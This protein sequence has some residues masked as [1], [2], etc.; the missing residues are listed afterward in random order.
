MPRK[1]AEDQL[2][3]HQETDSKLSVHC[4]HFC[5]IGRLGQ[6]EVD[7]FLAYAMWRVVLIFFGDL[8]LCSSI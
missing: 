3:I 2:N 8:V 5:K 6:A 7:L 4:C 1:S